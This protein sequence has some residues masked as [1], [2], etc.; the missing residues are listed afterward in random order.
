MSYFPNLQSQWETV[1]VFSDYSLWSLS[2]ALFLVIVI[3]IGIWVL[4]K[5]I[6]IRLEGLTKK[7]A[8]KVDDMLVES[9]ESVSSIFWWLLALYYP[10]QTL[11]L[12]LLVEKSINALWIFVCIWEIIRFVVRIVEF[13]LSD[14]AHANHTMISGVVI[15]LR[16]I[17]WSIGLLFLLSNLGI[18][19]SAIWA[20]LGIGG[21]AIALAAQNIFS[22]LFSSFSL[23]FDR[24]FDVGDYVALG[25]GQDGVVKRI[26]IRS[27]RISTLQGEELIVPNRDLVSNFVQNYRKM[28][29]RRVMINV[30]VEYDT[31]TEKLKKIPQLLKAACDSIGAEGKFIWAHFINFGASSLEFELAYYVLSGNYLR[32]KVLHEKVLFSIR[33]SFEKEG[34]VMAFPTRT[35]WIKKE[36][37]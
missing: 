18:N 36:N 24:P 6:L 31:K 30:G 37:P 7:T 12:P 34:I 3:F 8:T 9:L 29:Q 17:L 10:L 32:Y 23:Y 20:S 4:R 27:T 19:V 33:E 35:V 11:H 21:I 1:I 22:D 2:Y 14:K 5:I 13:I 28:E 15:F 26:G 25:N 16:I